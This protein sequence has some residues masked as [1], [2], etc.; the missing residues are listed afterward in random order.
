M[1]AVRLCVLFLSCLLASAW[2]VE[3]LKNTVDLRNVNYP[4][5]SLCHGLQLLLWF[6]QLVHEIDQDGILTL[7]SKC[8]PKRGDFGFS[9]F[10]N[11]DE[12]LPILSEEGKEYYSVGNLNTKEYPQANELLN[13]IKGV[14]N[15]CSWQKDTYRL[16]VS[17]HPNQPRKVYNAYI[18]AHNFGKDGFPPSTTYEIDPVLI[19]QI[20]NSKLCNVANNF[21]NYF[22]FDPRKKSPQKTKPTICYGQEFDVENRRIPTIIKGFEAEMQLY[23]KN[24]TACARLYIKKTYCKWLDDFN[25]S[26]V[27]FYNN[28]ESPNENYK[29][30]SYAV[31][32]KKI[33]GHDKKC[34]DVYEYQ[35]NLPIAPGVQIRFFPNNPYTGALAQTT[36]W[37]AAEEWMKSLSDCKNINPDRPND[38]SY[39]TDRRNIYGLDANRVTPIKIKGFKARMQ[40]YAKDGKA[41]ARI[42]IDKTFS[43][44]QDVFTQSW[45]GFYNSSQNPSETYNADVKRFEKRVG[46]SIKCYDIYEFQS[47]LPIAHGVQIRFFLNNARESELTQ[48]IP[49]QTAKE[50]MTSSSDCASS[51]WS[52]PET[53][54]ANS[55]IPTKIKEFGARLQLY[56]KDDKACARVYIEKTFSNWLNVFTESW[57]GFYNSSQDPN[58]RYV[59]Y[60]YVKNIQKVEGHSG[61][62]YDIYEY[63]SNSP[64]FP[65]VQIR[66]FLKNT[67]T[68]EIAKTTPW[69]PAE[70]ASTSPSDCKD[71][72]H[73]RPDVW[74]YRPDQEYN[75]GSEFDDL[76]RVMPTKIKGFEAS[77]QLYEK[78]G[79]ACARLYI[80][81]TFSEW[82]YDFA[83]S[84][85]GF[86]NP[87]QNPNGR[88]DA[89]EY[90]GNFEK[91]AGHGIKDYDIYE[92]ESS[93]PIAPGVQI[94][95]FL[96]D[97]YSSELAKSTLWEV[98]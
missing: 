44:W 15:T 54:D 3:R 5:P 97:S 39:L 79:K 85:V 8:N 88:Y 96:N 66:F 65:G 53:D 16:V 9:Y 35:S 68:S 52:D 95:F 29:T 60:E 2:T 19:Q 51:F 46:H 48:S 20:K 6:A 87:V 12:I 80:K 89:Y 33:I 4:R 24:G 38:L 71:L 26:W 41:C 13:Y 63:Q 42:Y 91:V 73:D 36:P 7:D 56:N 25:S 69:Q 76:N 77:L 58:E 45:V 17:M 50:W 82:Q 83:S 11:E 70:K 92:Y 1:V 49:W 90:V 98:V 22:S 84:W 32:F 78:Y 30:Y 94:S 64:I 31:Y 14:K 10:G 23:S 18:T 55:V 61:A 72:N 43:N 75:Y 74:S 93:L 57:V 86:Y 47:N 27:G 34:Y 21:C 81:K 37:K 62:C 40:L 59:K 28:S 67:Y